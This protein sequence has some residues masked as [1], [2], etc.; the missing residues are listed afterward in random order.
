MT[1]EPVETKITT[2]GDGTAREALLDQLSGELSVRGW[3]SQ[4]IFGLQMA[5]EESVAN[6]YR[7]GNLEG[8]RGNVEIH[9]S[10]SADAFQ[11]AISDQGLGFDAETVPDPTDIENLEEMSGRGLL[12][13]RNFMTE[14]DFRDGGRT[15]FMKKSKTPAPAD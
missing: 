9:W 5:V 15:V 1:S 11:I 13:M 12:L 8:Q 2:L 14:V 7:H 6:A 3:S 4:D 10:I